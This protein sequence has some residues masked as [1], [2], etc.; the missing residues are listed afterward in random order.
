MEMFLLHVLSLFL[1]A[2]G[3]GWV[4]GDTVMALLHV[5]TSMVRA[6]GRGGRDRAY[7]RF[8]PSDR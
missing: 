3:R 4:E 1:Q 8:H 6:G 5:M 7:G 2:G